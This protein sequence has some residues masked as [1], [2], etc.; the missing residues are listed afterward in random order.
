MQLLRWHFYYICETK[1]VHYS[2]PLTVYKGRECEISPKNEAIKASPLPLR[3]R[4]LHYRSLSPP[5]QLRYFLW[6]QC[7]KCF[8][9]F[10]KVF[11]FEN[12]M[13]WNIVLDSWP[14]RWPLPT[15]FCR[16]L[17]IQMTSPALLSSIFWLCFS[18]VVISEDVSSIVIKNEQAQVES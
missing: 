9:V 11:V 15:H 2:K 10:M 13:G 14:G 3:N 4:W 16:D 5:P 12:K 8:K 6:W 17:G 18:I 1:A 7:N